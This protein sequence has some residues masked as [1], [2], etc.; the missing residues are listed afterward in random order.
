LNFST[1]QPTCE[2]IW[3]MNTIYKAIFAA[4]P[5]KKKHTYSVFGI[6]VAVMVVIWKKLFYKK[7]F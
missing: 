4:A 2:T 3:I 1:L 5:P 7:Y 6:A